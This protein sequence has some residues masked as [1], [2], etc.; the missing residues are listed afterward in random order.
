MIGTG[1]G[2]RMRTEAWAV[3]QS[4]AASFFMKSYTAAFLRSPGDQPHD[5]AKWRHAELRGLGQ[6]AAD[7]PFVVMQH[8]VADRRVIGAIGLHQHASR[9]IA[10]TRA[11]GHLGH[12]FEG[13]PRRRESPVGAAPCRR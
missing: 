9:P 7:E 4:P 13:A 6:L 5:P 8:R 12:Q 1:A 2:P 10:A 11:A 3:W